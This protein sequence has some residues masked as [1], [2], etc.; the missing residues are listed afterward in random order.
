MNEILAK[1][2]MKEIEK[3]PKHNLEAVFNFQK[4]NLYMIW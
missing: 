4:G 1:Q 2:V 3:N